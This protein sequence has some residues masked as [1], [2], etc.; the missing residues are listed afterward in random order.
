MLE[1]DPI[2]QS[3][4]NLRSCTLFVPTNQA[5]Q[6]HQGNASL[7]YHMGECILVNFPIKIPL[8]I[9]CNSMV[10]LCYRRSWKLHYHYQ[11]PEEKVLSLLKAIVVEQ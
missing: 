9:F 7:L 10:K 5:F 4:V 6:K 2:A 1:R 3:T 11:Q 8:I